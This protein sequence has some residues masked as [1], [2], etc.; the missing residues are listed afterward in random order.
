MPDFVAY[1]KEYDAN[2]PFSDDDGGDD[3]GYG[4]W[5][6]D[7]LPLCEQAEDGY[8]GLSCGD[9]G[10]FTIDYFYDEYCLQSLGTYNNLYKLNNQLKTYKNCQGIYSSNDGDSSLLQYIVPY[11]ES[12]TSLDSN[13]CTDDSAMSSRRSSAGS[14]FGRRKSSSSKNGHTSWSTKLKYA[15]GG[16]LLLASFILFAGILFTNRRRRRALMQRKFKHSSRSHRDD[17]SRR[18]SKSNRNK[19]RDKDSRRSRT[20]RSRSR[21]R[22]GNMLT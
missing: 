1:L 10:S 14:G 21:G 8:L 20:K 2:S 15:L 19:A 3:D 16:V 4:G 17:K 5:S 13:L 9:D 12:C 11:S 7:E 22:D 18:T 6:L